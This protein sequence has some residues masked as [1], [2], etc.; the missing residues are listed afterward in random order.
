MTQLRHIS[1]LKFVV[2]NW[3]IFIVAH[4]K[5]QQALQNITQINDNNGHKYVAGCISNELHWHK[6]NA[7]P[8]KKGIKNR[9]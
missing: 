1:N 8:R 5:H 3:V 4:T 9:I 2:T 6:R 7:I